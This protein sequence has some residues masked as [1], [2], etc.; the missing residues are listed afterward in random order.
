MVYTELLS[1]EAKGSSHNL[2]V[3]NWNKLL[4]DLLTR[5]MISPLSEILSW[6]WR[7]CRAYSMKIRVGW[8]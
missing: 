8:V 4:I 3:S 1:R 2:T 7:V 5:Y 6:G